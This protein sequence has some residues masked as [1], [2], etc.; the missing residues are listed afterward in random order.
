MI[1]PFHFWHSPCSSKLERLVP[2]F[3]VLRQ[4]Q[5]W[6]PAIWNHRVMLL[7]IDW[8]VTSAFRRLSARDNASLV[9]QPAMRHEIMS[10]MHLICRS[11]GM[12][13]GGVCIEGWRDICFMELWSTFNQLCVVCGSLFP[14]KIL[15]HFRDT[16]VWLS[17]RVFYPWVRSCCQ[18]TQ[19]KLTGNARSHN[20]LKNNFYIHCC[21][22]LLPSSSGCWEW[23]KSNATGAS[24]QTFSLTCSR[25]SPFNH[26]GI[27]WCAYLSFT[28]PT[29]PS[30]GLWGPGTD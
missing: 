11:L 1:V 28:N 29:N 13:A 5:R 25:C 18:W 24:L 23:L 12:K 6:R 22:C 30:H 15:L 10:L 27:G 9:S 8:W 2:P 26:K 19:S 14:S 16:L 17:L 7:D 21:A 3:F 20:R 4:S